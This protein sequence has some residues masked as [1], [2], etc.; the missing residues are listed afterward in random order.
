MGL[1]FCC[2]RGETD[3]MTGNEEA[4]W[5]QKRY[6]IRTYTAQNERN[7]RTGTAGEIP[8]QYIYIGD[9]CFL[10]NGKVHGV[11]LP[12]E[13][14]VIGKQAF[15]GCQFQKAVEFP[16]SLV[17]IKKR[18]FAANKRLRRAYFPYTLEKLGV[19]CYR[20]CCNLKSAEFEKNSKCKV[21]PDGAFD[22]CVKLE[23]VCLPGAVRV[24]EKRAF[25]RC[26]ELKNIVLPNS[27]MEIG[28]EAFYFCGIEELE[29]PVNLKVIGDSAFF[30]CK[31][32][33]SVYIPE[34]VRVIGRWAFH[35]CSRLEKIE[36]LHDPDEIGPWIINKSCTIVCQKGSK[37]DAYAKEYE[38]KTEYVELTEELDG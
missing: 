32:L 6:D 4:G 22:S 15:E 9:K 7:R 29:L 5:N 12:P 20:E 18:A 11:V 24:I 28:E 38:L 17:E 25:Y 3:D 30:R 34:S 21:I 27:I 33:K 36:I 14:R 35:G 19:Q 23:T 1:C 2:L 31:N 26:K 13:C 16:E 37:V 8:A 10:N